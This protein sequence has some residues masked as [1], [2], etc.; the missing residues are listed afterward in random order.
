MWTPPWPVK[1]FKK[2]PSKPPLTVQYQKNVMKKEN[3]LK[4]EVGPDG[5]IY[6]VT[7]SYENGRK[8]IRK[9][10]KN[11]GNNNQNNYPGG[12][13]TV[14]NLSTRG[15]FRGGDIVKEGYSNQ[16]DLEKSG[17]K[18]ERYSYRSSNN[19]NEYIDSRYERPSYRSYENGEII[20]AN[21]S[22]LSR[23][24]KIRKNY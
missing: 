21:L 18:N 4:E 2:Q 19:N 5:Q 9:N 13:Y 22:R 12:S 14:S 24:A 3:I 23:E 7:T 6:Q 17:I 1:V 10:L 20:E 11:V 16:N 15:S 8:V